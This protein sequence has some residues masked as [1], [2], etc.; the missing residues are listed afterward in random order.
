MTA[1]LDTDQ[2]V[3]YWALHLA[4]RMKDGAHSPIPC[5]KGCHPS[6]LQLKS[7]DS[8]LYKMQ[9]YRTEAKL[10]PQSIFCCFLFLLPFLV[11]EYDPSL[12]GSVQNKPPREIGCH[13]RHSWPL[14]REENCLSTAAKKET[15]RPKL[16]TSSYMWWGYIYSHWQIKVK[17]GFKREL[18]LNRRWD[19]SVGRVL[20]IQVLRQT[21]IWKQA[22]NF[23]IRK[24]PLKWMQW[25]S[26]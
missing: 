6:F 8:A 11:M 1:G 22:E 21:S 16:D 9:F 23:D 12:V 15:L 4:I 10:A 18:S 26:F 3:K 5:S 7:L 17:K 2:G 14:S 24:L 20:N 25:Y 19:I 13:L